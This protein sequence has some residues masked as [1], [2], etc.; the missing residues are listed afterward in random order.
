MT[1]LEI[2]F[3]Q[4]D[5]AGLKALSAADPSQP[6]SPELLKKVKGVKA[7]SGEVVIEFK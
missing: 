3:D 2:D 5:E 1:L 7:S 6:P 4:I